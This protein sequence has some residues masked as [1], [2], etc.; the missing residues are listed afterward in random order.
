MQGYISI[1][2]SLVKEYFSSVAHLWMDDDYL[3]L[4]DGTVGHYDRRF[5]GMIVEDLASLAV[6]EYSQEDLRTD[7]RFRKCW[8]L[9]DWGPAPAADP[10]Q[11][12]GIAKVLQSWMQ[13]SQFS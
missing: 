8:A 6:C 2:E 1:P 12:A 11:P 10:Q 3:T 4:S 9:E 5:S 7:Q 13:L